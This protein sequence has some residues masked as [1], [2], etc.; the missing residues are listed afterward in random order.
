[1]QSIITRVAALDCDAMWQIHVEVAL[2]G[3]LRVSH[4]EIDLLES[5]IEDDSKH[6]HET[7]GEPR[8]DWSI[9][10]KVVDTIGLLP[11]MNVETSLLLLHFIRGQ[12]SIAPHGPD[13]RYSLMSYLESLIWE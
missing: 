2:D 10:L 7:N 11:T 1:M 13:G 9:G 4:D 3:S 5:P 12:V 8:N 6:N